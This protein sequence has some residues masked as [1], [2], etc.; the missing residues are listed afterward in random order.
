[1][2]NADISTLLKPAGKFFKKFHTTLFF[3]IIVAGLA[4]TVITIN[5]LLTEAS[6]P[7]STSGNE[8][9]STGNTGTPGSFDEQTIQK[10]NSLHESS[11]PAEVTLPEGR[12]SP[13][14][15]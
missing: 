5:T 6:D 10:I 8:L 3:V 1:M 13:F 9:P 14:S 11:S 2:K 4:F 7:T 15:E 12:I